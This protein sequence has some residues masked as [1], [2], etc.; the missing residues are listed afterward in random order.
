[1][2]NE[3]L[4]RILTIKLWNVTDDAWETVARGTGYSFEVNKETVDITSF[5]SNKWKEFLVD[6]KEATLSG[7]SLVLRTSESGK[8]NY[9]EILTSLIGSDE[10]FAIQIVNPNAA[11]LS[12]AETDTVLE[13]NAFAHELI[14]GFLTG[15]SLTGSLGD[16]QTF[17][18]KLQPTGNVVMV[19]AVYALAL[20]ADG[21][22]A[23][24]NDGDVILV[25]DQIA[26]GDTGY[27]INN[28]QTTWDDYAVLDTE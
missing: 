21:F 10:L 28:S 20:T 18:W 4:S 9:E 3:I 6:L 13:A 7:D 15:L 14:T 25:L 17:S 5:D 26:D 1:M 2:A 22:V 16:K 12:D 8:I 27:M 19:K 11:S 23:S 24:Y